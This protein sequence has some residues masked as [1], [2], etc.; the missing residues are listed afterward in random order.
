MSAA[1]RVATVS[2]A[3]ASIVRHVAHRVVAWK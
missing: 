1:N 3:Y 2:L